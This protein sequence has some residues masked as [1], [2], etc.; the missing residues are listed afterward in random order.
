MAAVPSKILKKE[1]GSLKGQQHLVMTA[2]DRLFH[3]F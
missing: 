3:G 2:I 1:I